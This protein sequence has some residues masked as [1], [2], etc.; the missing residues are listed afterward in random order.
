MGEIIQYEG[1]AYKKVDRQPKHGDV[2]I[3]RKSEGSSFLPNVPYKV[4]EKHHNPYVATDA[5][6]EAPVYDRGRGRT[7][8]TVDVYELMGDMLALEDE[9]ARQVRHLD[10]PFYKEA[11]ECWQI[12]QNGQIRKGAEKYPEPFN[13]AN[14]T[15]YELM[16]HA[17][18]ENVDQAHY[19]YGMYTKMYEMEQ[20]IQEL[21]EFRDNVQQTV[22][23]WGAMNEPKDRNA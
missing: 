19:I 7:E 15:I 4:Y 2:V 16:E 20:E 11:R 14:W 9:H 3:A 21:R 8:A 18:Q 1:V 23:K 12:T 22:V 13:P 10:H 17:M 5:I 6:W